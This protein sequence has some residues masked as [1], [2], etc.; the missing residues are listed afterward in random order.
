MALPTAK[1]RKMIEEKANQFMLPLWM[2]NGDIWPGSVWFEGL[3]MQ[4]S[5]GDPNARRYEKHQD[6]ESPT[7][8]DSPQVDDGEVEDDASYGLCQI[9]G[10]TA[11]GLLKLDPKVPMT[12]TFLYEPNLNLQLAAQLLHKLLLDVGLDVARALCRYNGGHSGDKIMPNGL[13]RRQEYVDLVVKRTKM[14]D[15]D[16]KQWRKQGI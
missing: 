5:A 1:Y 15:E 7:D 11:K 10:T 6:K 13:Y 14:V 2:Y 3:V 8:P 12:M 16:I 4:E 9:M